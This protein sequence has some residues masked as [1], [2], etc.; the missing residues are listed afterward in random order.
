MTLTLIAVHKNRKHFNRELRQLHKKKI[1]AEVKP[2]TININRVM[3]FGLWIDQE[4]TV[5][6]LNKQ[7]TKEDSSE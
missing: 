4:Y 5:E 6:Y 7:A 3:L 2:W 1:D